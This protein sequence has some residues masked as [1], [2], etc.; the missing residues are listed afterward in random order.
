MTSKK[1]ALWLI[2]LLPIA[3][4]SCSLPEV[5]EVGDYCENAE[6]YS[7]STG[8]IVGKFSTQSDQYYQQYQQFRFCPKDYPHCE[9]T[10]DDHV[11]CR[12]DCQGEMIFCADRCIDATNEHDHCGAKGKCNALSPEDTN[13]RGKACSPAQICKESQCS[14]IEEDQVLCDDSCIDPTNNSD[15]CG[16]KGLCNNESSDSNDYKGRKCPEAQTCRESKCVCQQKGYAF[17][18]D[19]CIDP[20]E[21]KSHCGAKGLC[22]DPFPD[23]ADFWGEACVQAQICIEGTCSCPDKT[24]ILCGNSCTD[25]EADKQHCGARGKCTENDENSDDWQGESCRTGF[26]CSGGKCRI[27][28]PLGLHDEDNNC[29]PDDSLNCGEKGL[30]C[31]EGQVCSEGKCADECSKSEVRCESETGILCVIPETNPLFC[32]ADQDCNGYTRC[33]TNSETCSNGRCKC[34]NDH[35]PNG[36]TCEPNDNENCGAHGIACTSDKVRNSKTAS[37]SPDGICDAASC[38]TGYHVY[39]GRCEP[40]SDEHCGNHGKSCDNK[41]VIASK[42]TSCTETGEC[43]ATECIPGYHVYNGGCE[44]DDIDNCGEHEKACTKDLVMGSETVSC[45]TGACL[46]TS[47]DSS[48]LLKDTVCVDKICTEEEIICVNDGTNGI[49]QK[50]QNNSWTIYDACENNYS[51]NAEGTGCGECINSTKKCTNENQTELGYTYTCTKGSWGTGTKCSS[52]YSCNADGTACGSCKN[53][54]N[55]CTNYSSIG[56]TRK[57]ANGAWSTPT[58]CES[59]S[60]NTVDKTCGECKNDSKRCINLEDATGY[61]QTCKSGTW[62]PTYSPV[63]GIDPSSCFNVSC[64]SAGTACGKCKNSDQPTCKNDENDGFIGKITRCTDGISTTESCPNNY[65]CDMTGTECGECKN[66]VFSCKDGKLTLCDYGTS[67]IIESCPGNTACKDDKSCKDCPATKPFLTKDGSDCTTYTSLMTGIK[68]GDTLYFGHY[69]KRNDIEYPLPI[70]WQVLDVQSNKAL[71]ITKNVIDARPY[72]YHKKDTPVT[73]ATWDKSTIRSWL[74]GLTADDNNAKED[75]STDNFMTMAFTE[76]E[77]QKI[78]STEITTGTTKTN[79]SIFILSEE[80]AARYMNTDEKRI[81]IPTTYAKNVKG[82]F[83]EP[84]CTDDSCATLW[85]LRTPGKNTKN[86]DN[87]YT[88]KYVFTDGKIDT[89]GYGISES[90]IG[91]RPAMWISK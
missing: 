17:C 41:S 52:N 44:K 40:N 5:P 22:S 8:K 11:F 72:H 19:T 37:C 34:R 35:H 59:V 45:D 20:A 69:Q 7:D 89:S 85:Y 10:K 65:S 27:E 6:Y 57:C 48:H 30:E 77:A 18:D 25:P 91:M 68:A 56:R 13:Y 67:N 70:E 84:D 43:K 86:E 31:E 71:I 3:V 1:L 75:Y 9:K 64:N 46:P 15:Y 87:Y 74:N 4:F 63:E 73:S 16:A 88:V 38:V 23:N 28:C 39:N 90:G 76:T 61:L 21:S 36:D 55:S 81:A 60:C 47:C 24:Q 49:L 53:N 29:V 62:K 54:T 80:E 50:C 33:D 2:A 58:S 14:C 78:V 42:N 82:A 12:S 66:D 79:D 51:C 32:D 26:M 83:I